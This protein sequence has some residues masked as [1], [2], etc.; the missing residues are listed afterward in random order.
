MSAS[1]SCIFWIRRYHEKC[2][3]SNDWKLFIRNQCIILE[4]WNRVTRDMF[5]LCS[6]YFI[7]TIFNVEIF[8]VIIQC[9][10]L[11]SVALK[12]KHNH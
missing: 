4:N 1:I 3:G 11:K 8:D 7:P 6:Y 9:I 12:L 10:Y 5:L 2:S